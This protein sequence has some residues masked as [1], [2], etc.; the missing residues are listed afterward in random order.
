[1]HWLLFAPN[2]NWLATIIFADKSKKLVSELLPRDLWLI[3]LKVDAFHL[4]EVI[5]LPRA[6]IVLVP[7]FN[8]LAVHC[9]NQDYQELPTAEDLAVIITVQ[10]D[11]PNGHIFS[12]G[13][14]VVAQKDTIRQRI[15]KD[16][17]VVLSNV[18]VGKLR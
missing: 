6:S 11:R 13:I 9:S 1:M 16:L 17:M 8:T 7:P 2:L 10:L 4:G 18:R 15:K 5:T 14:F 3:K 12:W